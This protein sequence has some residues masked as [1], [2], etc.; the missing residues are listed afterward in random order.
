MAGIQEY[1]ACCI[2]LVQ[3]KSASSFANSETPLASAPQSKTDAVHS[4]QLTSL[5]NST[6]GVCSDSTVAMHWSY[7]PEWGQPN[8]RIVYITGT[9]STPLSEA[10]K[11]GETS[12]PS[13]ST[14]FSGHNGSNTISKCC[15]EG[16]LGHVTGIIVNVPAAK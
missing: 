7:D 16:T 15:C 14:P 8:I 11:A 9:S 13:G 5:Q 2:K 10:T 1:L 12:G 4:L 3:P 6:W